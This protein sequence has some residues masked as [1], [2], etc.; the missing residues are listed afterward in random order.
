[1]GEGSVSTTLARTQPT[2]QNACRLVVEIGGISMGLWCERTMVMAL[3]R[4]Q[5][6]FVVADP[7]AEACAMELDVCWAESLQMP[8]AL[9]SFVSGG[10]WSAFREATGTKFYFS[11]RVLGIAPY[12]AAWFDPSF[13]RG[14]IVIRKDCFAAGQPIFPLEY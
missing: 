14:H 8:S 12:K 3:D 5:Y 13:E 6:P 10:L 1:M 4:E 7:E 2:G 11:S 9:P